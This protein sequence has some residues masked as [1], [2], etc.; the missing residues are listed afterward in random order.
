MELLIQSPHLT[1]GEYGLIE[2]KR[3]AQTGSGFCFQRSV[4][5]LYKEE[6]YQDKPNKQ[7]K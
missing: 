6:S 2:E 5:Y 4:L 7:E 1:S 3:F